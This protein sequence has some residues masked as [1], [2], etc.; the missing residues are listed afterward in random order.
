MS[1]SLVCVRAHVCLCPC[2]NTVSAAPRRTVNHPKKWWPN[3]LV[4]Y[5]V[6]ASG[7]FRGQCLFY[8][9]WSMFHVFF[10]YFFCNACCILYGQCCLYFFVINAACIFVVNA[11]YIFRGQCLYISL[12]GDKFIYIF[13]YIY[14]S[15]QSICWV[16]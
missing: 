4:F 9:S 12:Q 14:I 10:F 5:V 11:S 1:V 6:N 13:I 7:I 16:D 2:L 3:L 15:F 8:F